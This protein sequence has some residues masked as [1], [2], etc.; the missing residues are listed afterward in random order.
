MNKWERIVQILC[1]L[2][3]FSVLISCACIH[4]DRECEACIDAGVIPRLPS[5]SRR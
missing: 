2:A 1:C 4:V 5:N 3:I